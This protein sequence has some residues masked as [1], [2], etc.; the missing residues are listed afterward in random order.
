M[1]RAIRAH[2]AMM[3]EVADATGGYEV[4]AE[5]DAFM[6]A[7][8]KPSQALRF[9][10]VAQEA[11]ARMNWREE[12]Q[13][14]QHERYRNGPL[15]LRVRMGIHEGPAERR[16]KP[17][18]GRSDYF[19]GAVNIAARLCDMG[20]G[21]Q[22]LISR[23]TLEELQEPDSVELRPLGAVRVMWRLLLAY[24]DERIAKA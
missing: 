13:D 2:D 6:L 15:G 11:L 5:G 17:H 14:H 12:L 24:V 18:T 4:K 16:A 19:G 23:A 10:Q 21:A 20:H 22:V 9:A 7:Y 3:R 8:S 1:T